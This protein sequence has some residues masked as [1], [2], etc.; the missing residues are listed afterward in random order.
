ML[1]RSARANAAPAAAPT[2]AG[3]SSPIAHETT[4]STCLPAAKATSRLSQT[5]DE[6]LQRVLP[7]QSDSSAKV[8][9]TKS[10]CRPMQQPT[11]AALLRSTHQTQ[12]HPSC[13]KNSLSTTCSPAPCRMFPSTLN[14]LASRCT[15]SPRYQTQFRSST[16]RLRLKI[17]QGRLKMILR[18]YVSV[19]AMTA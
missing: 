12:T 19:P 15:H 18:K 6:A 17:P 7:D 13:S 10:L 1:F 4:D 2:E 9:R 11:A 14:I 16:L 3:P 8:I 5:N